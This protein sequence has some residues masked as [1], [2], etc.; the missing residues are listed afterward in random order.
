MGA[1]EGKAAVRSR[2]SVGRIVWIAAAFVR[3]S[4]GH[5]V[6]RR[7]GRSCGFVG[8]QSRQTRIAT[9]ETTWTA[10]RELLLLSPARALWIPIP[11]LAATSGVPQLTR[12]V[13]PTAE[14]P[15]VVDRSSVCGCGGDSVPG[16]HLQPMGKIVRLKP[17][18]AFRREAIALRT[19]P[20][21][22]PAGLPRPAGASC[23][24]DCAARPCHRSRGPPGTPD[25][26][27][28]GDDG[29]CVDGEGWRR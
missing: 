1:R 21:T 22:A 16:P 2:M 18:G 6:R 24:L 4:G 17:H 7:S 27:P 26:N 10:H 25:P 13:V 14:H 5:I 9:E 28:G 29:A 12:Y 20:P 15:G 23:C 3:G 11:P 8:Y 19:P